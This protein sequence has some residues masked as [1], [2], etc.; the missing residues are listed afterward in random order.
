MVVVFCSVLNKLQGSSSSWSSWF[1]SRQCG[2]LLIDELPGQCLEEVTVGMFGFRVCVLAG[3]SNHFFMEHRQS[4][5]IPSLG[6][7]RGRQVCPLDTHNAGD[8]VESLAKQSVRVASISCSKQYRYAGD[9]IS[10]IQH[11]FPERFDDLQCPVLDKQTFVVPHVF[12]PCDATDSWEYCAGP[13]DRRDRG[14]VIRRHRLVFAQ[15]LAVVAVEMVLAQSRRFR[16][17][18]CQLL[19]LWCLKI[20]LEELV[21]LLRANV[22]D[23]CWQVH[24]LLGEVDPGFDYAG[25][26][27]LELWISVGRFQYKYAQNAHGTTS[28]VVLWFLVRRLDV[29]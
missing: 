2:L 14:L 26:Y 21:A 20:P 1:L 19:I 25:T 22:V 4:D 16:H 27:D 28:E 12:K 6:S 23:A 8:W 11:V 17:G 9:S 7:T 3:D 5:A 18:K 24:E 15:V 29:D 10:F 13:S